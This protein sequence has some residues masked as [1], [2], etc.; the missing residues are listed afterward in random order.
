M[1]TGRINQVAIRRRTRSWELLC[2]RLPSENA[3]IIFVL[4]FSEGDHST[5]GETGRVCHCDGITLCLCHIFPKSSPQY[6][7]SIPVGRQSRRNAT[8]I[9]EEE[10]LFRDCNCILGQRPAYTTTIHSIVVPQWATKPTAKTFSGSGPDF[11]LSP[12]KCR[13]FVAGN[14]IKAGLTRR[15]LISV[16]Q[17][18]LL[19][20]MTH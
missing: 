1:T 4:F 13:H 17:N 20:Q 6:T 9:H 8:E 2:L 5:V 7:W 3:R 19:H 10:S 12:T 14:R 15:L 11:T 16:L 18:L